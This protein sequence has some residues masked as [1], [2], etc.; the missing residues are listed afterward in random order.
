MNTYTLT[1]ATRQRL[2]EIADMNADHESFALLNAAPSTIGFNGLTEAE[3]DESMSVRGLSQKA[4]PSTSP[5]NS[6]AEENVRL[7]AELQRCMKER[8]ALRVELAVLKAAPS[9]ELPFIPWSK[10]AEMMEAWA[11]PSTSPM[12]DQE[13]SDVYFGATSQSLRPADMFVVRLFAHAVEA[14]AKAIKGG[15]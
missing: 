14:R 11:A 13:I 3:T 15:A 7:D 1:E 12:T 10:E 2:M 9:Y 4:A 6:D 5:E 8:D